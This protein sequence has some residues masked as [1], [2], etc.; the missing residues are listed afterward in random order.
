[1]MIANHHSDT[2]AAFLNLLTILY[3]MLLARILL[4][5]RFM[6]NDS[7]NKWKENKQIKNKRQ[8]RSKKYKKENNSLK[9]SQE[10]QK[11]VVLTL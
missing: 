1:M 8:G 10:N 5:C 7:K 3:S 9:R 6:K 11:K 2:P 4:L